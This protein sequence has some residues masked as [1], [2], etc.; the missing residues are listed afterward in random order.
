MRTKSLR[1]DPVFK[2]MAQSIMDLS[3]GSS[4]IFVPSP[5]NWGDALINEGS[6][7][8]FN[9]FGIKTLTKNRK[10]ILEI[11]S[12]GAL[13]G[14]T[15]VVGGGG[16]WCNNWKTTPEFVSDLLEFNVKIVL[17]PTTFEL[18][19]LPETFDNRIRYF[20]RHKPTCHRMDFCHDMAFF[21]DLDIDTDNYGGSWRLFAMRGDIEASPDK[22]HIPRSID[23]SM[24]GNS[25]DTVRQ[26]FEI[27]S[28]FQVVYTDRLHVAIACALMEI[29]VY[30]IEGNYG[31]V[32]GVFNASMN[33]YPKTSMTTWHELKRKIE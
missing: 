15:I 13:D 17:L 10:D 14:S 4:V 12:K 30:A 26:F 7:Q 32:Q 23:I 29:E 27:L 21:I 22:F 11:L 18:D 2:A 19:L 16:G 28:R 1:D 31:K 24:L 8:F 6:R 9:H 3:E 20:S 25:Y 5:G 33:S